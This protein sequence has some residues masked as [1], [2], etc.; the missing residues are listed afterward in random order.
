MGKSLIWYLDSFVSGMSIIKSMLLV[1][2]WAIAFPSLRFAVDA[3]ER[4][5]ILEDRIGVGRTRL[6]TWL[7]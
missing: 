3:K 5:A 6:R 1:L 4:L 7:R 2:T